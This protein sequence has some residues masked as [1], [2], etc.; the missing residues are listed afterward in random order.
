MQPIAFALTY[1]SFVNEL[2]FLQ[3]PIRPPRFTSSI[4]IFQK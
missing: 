2:I 4:A 3:I 1:F